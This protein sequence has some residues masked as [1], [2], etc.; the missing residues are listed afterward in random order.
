MRLSSSL[1]K[2]HERR[3]PLQWMN[4]CF[5]CIH[6]RAAN[7]GN[8]KSYPVSKFLG[9]SLGPLALCYHVPYFPAFPFTSTERFMTVHARYSGAC[10][11]LMIYARDVIL[12]IRQHPPKRFS[13]DDF[14][15]SATFSPSLGSSTSLE[16]FLATDHSMRSY[17]TYYPKDTTY[18]YSR[19]LI[20]YRPLSQLPSPLENG[21]TTPLQGLQFSFGRIALTSSTMLIS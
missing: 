5:D 8:G 11:F 4:V 13:L 12:R 1:H 6:F 20:D 3:L 9:G 7:D 10:L 17:P 19:Q 16:G 15:W 14:L 2:I 18:Q 21:P